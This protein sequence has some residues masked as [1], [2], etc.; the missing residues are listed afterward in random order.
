[1]LDDEKKTKLIKTG[2]ISGIFVFST[3]ILIVLAVLSRRLWE[4]GL[5]KNVQTVLT[6][7]FPSQQW[8]VMQKIDFSS[9]QKL[10]TAVFACSKKSDKNS[11]YCAITR[12]PGI[13]GAQAAV[14]L[15]KTGDDRAFFVDYYIDNGKAGKTFARKFSSGTIDYWEKQL[16]KLID[17]ITDSSFGDKAK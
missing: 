17:G 8:Q 15:Y 6:R 3:A 1:M 16:K 14:F 2:I 11:Y 12:I 13:T 9:S 10:K 7:S 4:T 5:R